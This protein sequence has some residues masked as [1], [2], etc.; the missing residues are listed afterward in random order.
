MV[1][2]LSLGKKIDMGPV[3]RLKLQEIRDDSMDFNALT[4]AEISAFCSEIGV[5]VSNSLTKARMIETVSS[6]EEFAEY[7][8]HRVCSRFHSW[9][10]TGN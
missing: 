5:S 7:E 9:V 4:K 3:E 6:S 10:M 2:S 1:Y 8:E